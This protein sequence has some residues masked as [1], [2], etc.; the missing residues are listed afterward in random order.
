MNENTY[1]IILGNSIVSKEKEKTALP[2][3]IFT[4]WLS[5]QRLGD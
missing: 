3:G 2:L 1:F 5:S 4:W